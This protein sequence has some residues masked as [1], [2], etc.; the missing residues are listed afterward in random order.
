MF[1][2]VAEDGSEPLLLRVLT[3]AEN[4]TDGGAEEV[5]AVIDTGFDGELTLPE[6]TIRRLGYPYAGS[7]G[8]TLADG[9]EVQFNYHEGRV[10]WHRQALSVVVIAAEGQP[11]VG[12]ALLRGSRLQMDVEPGGEVV[13]EERN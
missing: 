7:A 3:E 10:L 2:S 4:G 11:L 1:G 13:I 9:G 5:E 6:G 12:M 8:G